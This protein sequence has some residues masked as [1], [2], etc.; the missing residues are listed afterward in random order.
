MEVERPIR[1]RGVRW[2]ILVAVL[3]G[4]AALLAVEPIRWVLPPRFLFK[5]LDLY[6]LGAID[7]TMCMRVPVTQAEAAA[8][9]EKQ[10]E[11]DELLARPVPVDQGLCPAKFWPRRFNTKTLAYAE[12][13]WPN[14]MVEGSSGAVYE[15]GYL[16]YWAWTQ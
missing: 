5:P 10:F 4:A 2:L 12:T 8:F 13:R 11:K 7:F 3:V 16:Y 14:G 1:L 15:Q 6:R 9:A